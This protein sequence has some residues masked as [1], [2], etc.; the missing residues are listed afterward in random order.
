M[1]IDNNLITDIG[2]LVL[3]SE[4]LI[5]TDWDSVSI[6]FDAGE[7][8]VANSG[9]IYKD[10]KIIPAIADIEDKPL[11]L[12]DKILE[13]REAIFNSSGY[14]FSQLLVQV[15]KKTCRIKIDFEFDKPNRWTILPAKLKEIGEVLRPKFDD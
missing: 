6:V 4:D 8:H 9:F 13:I 7:G 15:E 2:N 10:E 1:N 3:Q 12:R 11:I 14:K 5:T